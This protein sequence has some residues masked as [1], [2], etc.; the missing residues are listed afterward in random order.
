MIGVEKRKSV[1]ARFASLNVVIIVL[2]F[3]INSKLPTWLYFHT[4]RELTI[5][6]Y[7]KLQRSLMLSSKLYVPLRWPKVVENMGPLT[8]MRGCCANYRT[9]PSMVLMFW[10]FKLP[11]FIEEMLQVEPK[12]PLTNHGN[13][14]QY[15]PIFEW[16]MVGC[17]SKSG[18]THKQHK[19]NQNKKAQRRF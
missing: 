17:G 12:S 6:S 8:C 18:H 3:I 15:S 9:L 2:Y 11:Y 16:Y 10:D 7:N 19:T 5:I 13:V 1:S 4:T 14:C